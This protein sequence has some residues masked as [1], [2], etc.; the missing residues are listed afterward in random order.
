MDIRSFFGNKPANQQSVAA[1]AADCKKKATPN[2]KTAVA[3]DSSDCQ[4]ENIAGTADASAL[5]PH[6]V[7][8]VAELDCKPSASS[9]DNAVGIIPD[10]LKDFV[11]WQPGEAGNYLTISISLRYRR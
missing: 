6:V 5:V 11:T 2:I 9:V 10:D 7:T 4:K 1:V 8:N 3:V